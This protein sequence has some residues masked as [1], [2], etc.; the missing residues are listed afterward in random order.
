MIQN[1]KFLLNLS[2]SNIKRIDNLCGSL[3]PFSTSQKL[4]DR[5][6][7]LPFAKCAA[8][9]H[10]QIDSL[11]F[12]RSLSGYWPTANGENNFHGTTILSVRKGN[13]VVIIGDGQVSQGGTIVKDTAVKVGSLILVYLGRF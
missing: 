10:R 4:L 13:K 1:T 9:S 6:F 3:K 5:S 11:V 2:K 7:G 8:K 12:S